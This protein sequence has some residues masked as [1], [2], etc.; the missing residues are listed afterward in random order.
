[1]S[2]EAVRPGGRPGRRARKAGERSGP[3][4]PTNADYPVHAEAERRARSYVWED[5]RPGNALSIRHG[6]TSERVVGPLASELAAWLVAEFPDVGEPRYRFSVS[7]WSRAEAPAALLSLFLDARGIVHGDGDQRGEPREALLKSLRAEER[8]ATEERARLGL[9]PADH[10][11]LER[12][13][14]EA[15]AGV[16]SLDGIRAVGREALERRRELES[17]ERLGRDA[18][19]EASR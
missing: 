2:D 8:R 4:E 12:Q 6:A 10:A 11:K 16:A 18:D 7:A 17:A 15:V 14:A 13:R 5:F 9:S 1:V 19:R 3:A